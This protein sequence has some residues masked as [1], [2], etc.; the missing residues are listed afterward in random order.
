MRANYYKINT[1]IFPDVIKICFSDEQFQQIL[2]DYNINEKVTAFDFGGAETHFFKIDATAVI[3]GVFSLGEMGE[4]IGDISS[5]L[6]HEASH[7]VDD[8][9]ELIG[10]DHITNEVRAYFMQFLVKHL[11]TCVHEEK[12]QNARKQNRKL[13]KQ[14]GRKSRGTEPKVDQ[15]NNGGAGPNSNVEKTDLVRGTKVKHWSGVPKA[16]DSIQS[17]IATGVPS[18]DNKLF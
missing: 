16:E 12:A 1:G 2:K 15:H 18:Y 11:W 13:S 10:E 5:T 8:M 17:I 6:A 14:T 7:I 3:I 4:D 9:A